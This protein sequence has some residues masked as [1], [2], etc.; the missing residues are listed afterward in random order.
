M[1]ALLCKNTFQF[2]I[3]VGYLQILAEESQ[4]YKAKQCTISMQQVQQ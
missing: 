1:Q 4:Q 2:M 3:L